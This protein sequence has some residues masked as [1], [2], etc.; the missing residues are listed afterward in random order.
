VARIAQARLQ[1]CSA[2]KATSV[3]SLADLAARWQENRATLTPLT[4]ARDPQLEQ[5]I[6]NLIFDTEKQ[7]AQACGAPTGDDALLL[8]IAQSSRSVEEK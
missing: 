2:S 8:K 1:A 4:L 7:T 5:T 6:M 3:A